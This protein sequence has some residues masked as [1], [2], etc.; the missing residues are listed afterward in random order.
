MKASSSFVCFDFK[1]VFELAK[2]S[3]LYLKMSLVN[4]NKSTGNNGL[5]HIYQWNLHTQP[6]FTSSKLTIE[7]IEQGVEFVQS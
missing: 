1:H 4:V 7:I 6:V 2:S 5:T 3:G